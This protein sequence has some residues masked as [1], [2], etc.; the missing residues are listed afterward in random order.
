MT[1][2]GGNRFHG[3]LFEYKRDDAL[4]SASKYD[5]KKQELSLDQFG[6]SI[7]G[8]LRRTARSSSSASSG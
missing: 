1:K 5:D 4:D 7:G 6:G 8:P 3:S 2:S